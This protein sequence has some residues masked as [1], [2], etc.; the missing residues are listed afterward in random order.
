MKSRKLTILLFILLSSLFSQGQNP[1]YM[2]KTLS[3]DYSASSF[4]TMGLRF[5]TEKRINFA[6]LHSVSLTKTLN[7]HV[8][9]SGVFAFS[10][11]NLILATEQYVGY[12]LERETVETKYNARWFGGEFHFYRKNFVAPVGSYISLGYSRGIFSLAQAEELNFDSEN[13]WQSDE[14]YQYEVVKYNCN[15]FT[16]SLNNKKM[17]KG[18]NV[19]LLS[20][21]KFNWVTGGDLIAES[22]NGEGVYDYNREDQALFLMSRRQRL[23]NLFAFQ[24]GF[25]IL[26]I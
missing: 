24:L 3:V 18:S 10:N 16:L 13:N 5:M 11:P 25:G 2:G 8:S 14:L 6:L 20:G 12:D 17:I 26:A 4:P 19:Y 23:D 15:K 1:G 7:R 22:V 21:I 9:F